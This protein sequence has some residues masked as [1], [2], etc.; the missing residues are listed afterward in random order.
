MD[1]L[2]ELACFIFSIINAI[3]DLSITYIVPAARFI[4]PI[5]SKYLCLLVSIILRLFFTYVSPCIIRGLNI[6]ILAF[7]YVLNGI[8]YL[9]ITILDIETNLIDL[10]AII[11]CTIIIAI[12]YFRISEKLFH[13]SQEVFHLAAVNGRFIVHLVQMF[14]SFVTYL[15]RRTIAIV[16]NRS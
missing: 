13:F 1:F 6:I 7:F 5:L 3:F 10:R 11:L 12:I 9:S 2:I 4:L 8:G 16:S 14:V 15:Y